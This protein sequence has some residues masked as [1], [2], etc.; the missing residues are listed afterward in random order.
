MM[1][2][3]TDSDGRIDNVVSLLD[4]QGGRTKGVHRVLEKLQGKPQPYPNVANAMVILAHDPALAGML[5]YSE[6][7]LSPLMLRPPPPAEEG[8]T[9]LPGPYPR[10]WSP[11]DS[12][13]I[14]SYVQRIWCPK[15]KKGDLA[16]AMWAEASQRRF[17]PVRDWLASLRWDGKPRI[18]TWLRK[19]FAA[20]DDDYHAVVGAKFLIACVRRVR[21]PGCKFDQLVI[22]E[23]PQGLGKSRACRVLFSSKW[24]SDSLHPDLSSRDA[25]ISLA[26]AWGVELGEIQHFIRNDRTVIKAFLSRQVD[27]YRPV[28]G[29]FT[30]D[31]PRQSVLIGS[32]NQNVYLDDDTG[33][34]RIW[35]VACKECRIEWLGE[36]REQLWAEAA[37]REAGGEALWIDDSGIRINV[38]TAQAERLIE[39]VWSDPIADYLQGKTEARVSDVLTSALNIPRH[40]QGRGQEM[41]VAAILRTMEWCVKVEKMGRKS[42][43]VWRP[44]PDQAGLL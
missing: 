6:F 19:V 32:T 28:N 4:L 12:A 2:E 29:K 22:L 33:N 23:G 21:Q 40:L 14:L 25:P 42:V 5:G 3:P 11:E 7:I 17:H 26:G 43:R 20:P 34:R 24:F 38:E 10:P 9:L 8:A 37:A 36:N 1:P 39:D 16:E 31:V 13:L 41:R 18:D 44:P 30:I 15:M 35:P 27:R